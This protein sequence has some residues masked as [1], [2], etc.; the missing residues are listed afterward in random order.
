M[1]EYATLT[2]LVAVF[3]TSLGSLQARVAAALTGSDAVAVRQALVQARSVGAPPAGA[4]AA[5]HRAPYRR[6]AL[7]YVYALGWE[8]GTTRRTACALATLDPDGN[9]AATLKAIRASSV[10]LRRLA[11]LRVTATQGA[12]AFAAGFLSACG[13]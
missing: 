2:A 9:R 13:G 1:V 6:P 7:R 5:Y 10:T 12:T 4:A 8:S 3:S 11:R